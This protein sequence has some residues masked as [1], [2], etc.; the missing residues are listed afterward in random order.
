MTD[1]APLVLASSSP[2]RAELLKAAGIAF[3]VRPVDVD[4]RVRAGES[5]HDYVLR[6]ATEKARALSV[7]AGDVI[8]AADTTVVVDGDILGKPVNAAEATSML[9]RL[10][11]RTHQVLTGVCVL[12]GEHVEAQVSVSEVEFQDMDEREIRWYVATGEP[13]DKAGAYGIQ[14]L[15]SRFITRVRGSYTNVV[16]L[17]VAVVYEMLKRMASRGVH[18]AR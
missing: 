9:T 14:G 1:A 17:P 7:S 18:V 16:G 4:E 2:R 10:S 11:G 3:V 12:S 6:L 13:M 15:G 5:P 8:L